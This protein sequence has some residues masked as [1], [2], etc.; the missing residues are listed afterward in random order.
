MDIQ[1]ELKK[2]IEYQNTSLPQADRKSEDEI[3]AIIENIIDDYKQGNYNFNNYL[4]FSIKQ[5]HKMRKVKAFTLFSCEEA[6][7]I[8]LKRTLDKRYHIKYPN[9]TKYMHSLFD[10]VNALRNM[11]TY[12]IFRFDFEDY[13]NTVSC[14]YV[15]KKFI[16]KESLEREQMELLR[17]YVSSVKYAYAGLNT[18]NIFCEIIAQQF[19][20]CLNRQLQNAGLIYYRRYIDDGIMIFNKPIQPADCNKIVKLALQEVYYD[21]TIDVSQKCT[22]RLNHAKTKYISAQNIIP[23]GVPASFDFLGYKFEL[24][25]SLRNNKLT[26]EIKYGITDAKID[27]YTKRIDK[28]IKEYKNHNDMELMRHQLKA[29]CCRTVYQITR[30]KS[31]IWKTKGFISNY[32]EL[33]YRLDSLTND[34]ESFLKNAVV[35]AFN[36]NAV[37]VPYFVHRF[38]IKSP[39]Y[40]LYYSMQKYRTL[41]FVEPIGIC[42]NGLD[43]LCRQIGIYT[44]GKQ[45][46]GLVRDYLIK[47]K[48]GH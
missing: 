9:R 41:L 44:Y 39:N 27:K 36:R 25:P 46:D 23:Q 19:D 35:D 4:H 1:N 18:S 28:I 32:Q 6:L 38:P 40:N 45:Y 34:T 31:L 21:N 12:T 10:I 8:Y 42:R 37:A 15:F 14:E 48:V 24:T 26:T 43:K 29:F 2:I 13:F 7:C 33:R 22:T 3:N 11:N 20:E 17:K 16:S 30:Y 47:V 5:N